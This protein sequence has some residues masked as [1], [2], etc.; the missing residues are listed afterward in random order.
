FRR[1]GMP[2]E[3][4]RVSAIVRALREDLLPFCHDKRDPTY[5]AHLD[6]PPAD[7]SIAAGV[8]VRALAQDPVTWTSSRAGTFVEQ[9]VLRWFANL[10]F[11]QAE[12]AGGV[13]C[14]GGTQ[15]NFHAV[16]LARNLALPDSARL[17]IAAALRNSG[18]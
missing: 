3:G 18:V 2:E 7:L 5:T 12:H 4:D 9:E 1:A 11:T 15:A 10:A 16:L 8:L 14:A 6:I 13:A 17:G